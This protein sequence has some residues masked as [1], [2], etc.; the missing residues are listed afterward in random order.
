MIEISVIIR[1]SYCCS[2]N[3]LI[4][5]TQF[6]VLRFYLKMY[7]TCST[8]ILR[9]KAFLFS[10]IFQ[11]FFLFIPHSCFRCLHLVSRINAWL[12]TRPDLLTSKHISMSI[13]YQGQTYLTWHYNI[14]P[15]IIG[16]EMNITYRRE[17]WQNRVTRI[18]NA[19]RRLVNNFHFNSVTHLW[20]CQ[21][22]ATFFFSSLPIWRNYSGLFIRLCTILSFV[23]AFMMKCFCN[24]ISKSF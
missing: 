11:P 7:M 21:S 2:K 20:N 16:E 6:V 4:R 14:F 1:C 5:L 23:I 9:K 22:M 8:T 3:K 13:K 12:I 24:C 15:Q 19:F 10:N 17:I 18:V